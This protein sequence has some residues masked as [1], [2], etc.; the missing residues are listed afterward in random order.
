[1]RKIRPV[2]CMYKDEGVPMTTELLSNN[3]NAHPV[4]LVTGASS[5]VGEATAS[6]LSGAGYRVF[7]T[8]RES[9]LASDESVQMLSLDVRSDQSVA[10]SVSQLLEK[11]G[12]IDVLVNNAGYELSGALEEVSLDEMRAQFE[13]NLFGVARMVTAVLPHMRSRGSG[14]IVNVSSLLGLI[15]GPFLGA[16]SASKFAL[17]GYTEALRHEV[18]GFG[19]HVSL[20][21]AGFLKTQLALH[22][23]R[24][25]H[26]I[27]A[28]DPWR[29]KNFAIADMTREAA[30]GPDLVADAIQHI[31]AHRAPALRYRV[32]RQARVTSLQQRLLPAGVFERGVRR[33]FS[34]DRGRASS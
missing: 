9:R 21:E 34:M 14:R 25:A 27:S 24:A 8:S 22:G 29:M 18:K 15:G 32:G 10:A 28:Y 26:S 3:H 12:Q 5:G 7:G 20:V 1:M 16:Y 19:I 11:A 33:A 4:V 6:L 17:E 13:T 2:R 31:V 30:P 23:Q